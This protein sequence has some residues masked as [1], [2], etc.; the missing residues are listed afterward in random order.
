MPYK[1]TSLAF[2]MHCVLW[3]LDFRRLTLLADDAHATWYAQRKPQQASRQD[4]ITPPST[5]RFRFRAASAQL[6]PMSI[7][8]SEHS[9]QSIHHY[10]DKRNTDTP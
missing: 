7:L 5:G 3:M 6:I 2:I 4:T 1:Y 8:I 10:N 9:P